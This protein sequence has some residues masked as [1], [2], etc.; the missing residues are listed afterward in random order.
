MTLVIDDSRF[1]MLYQSVLFVTSLP[2]CLLL[3][4]DNMHQVINKM[5][6]ICGLVSVYCLFKLRITVVIWT[7]N[8]IM[9]RQYNYKYINKPSEQI[10][11]YQLLNRYFPIYSWFSEFCMWCYK[12][13]V[14][15][16]WSKYLLK[17][18]ILYPW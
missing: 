8:K 5:H 16:Y 15:F 13:L 11:I 1:D 2:V 10:L 14:L 17:L 18:K 12:T 4:T 3:F 9:R 6:Q 7:P